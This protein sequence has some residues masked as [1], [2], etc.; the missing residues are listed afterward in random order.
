MG[1]VLISIEIISSVSRDPKFREDDPPYELTWLDNH[2][3]FPFHFCH[4]TGWYES[5]GESETLDQGPCS[6]YNRYREILCRSVKGVSQ[7]QWCHADQNS[8]WDS[9]DS[10]GPHGP[11]DELIL[12]T[13]SR[14]VMDEKVVRKLANDFGFFRLEP[15]KIVEAVRSLE[16]VGDEATVEW[17]AGR[18][19]KWYAEI[20]AFFIRAADIKAI[21]RFC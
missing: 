4:G 2:E 11:F 7:K 19:L 1:L 10:G 6:L 20:A 21:I 16:A 17:M 8:G 3:G 18:F 15:G 5:H 14:G 9:I 12:F 13:D